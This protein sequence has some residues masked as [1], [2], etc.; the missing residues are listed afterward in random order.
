MPKFDLL[1]KKTKKS[2]GYHF[3][4]FNRSSCRLGIPKNRLNYAFSLRIWIRAVNSGNRLYCCGISLPP[5]GSNHLPVGKKNPAGRIMVEWIGLDWSYVE[6]LLLVGWAT[7]SLLQSHWLMLWN[8][9]SPYKDMVS[10]IL[11]HL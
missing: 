10:L 4:R 5:D 7:S 3:Y 1:K 9:N 8:T 2:T 11:S 6:Y